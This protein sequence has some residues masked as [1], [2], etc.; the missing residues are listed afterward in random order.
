MSRK[1]ISRDGEAVI[2][3]GYANSPGTLVVVGVRGDVVDTYR[4]DKHNS[5]GFHADH[6]YKFNAD[7]FKRLETAFRQKKI[8]ELER[9]WEMA[10]PFKPSGED[11]NGE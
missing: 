9:L 6:V 4:A 2:V 5:M 3:R 11:A 7:L 10:E 8:K 1:I